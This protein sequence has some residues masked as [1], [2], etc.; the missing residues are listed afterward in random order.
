[1]PSN[2]SGLAARW[3]SDMAMGS[4]EDA[5]GVAATTAKGVGVCGESVPF[6]WQL[7]IVSKRIRMRE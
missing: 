3:V 7:T 6:C 5:R 2:S 1:V 4:A